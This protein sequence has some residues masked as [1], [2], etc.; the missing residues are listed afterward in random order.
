MLGYGSHNRNAAEQAYGLIEKGNLDLAPLI[1]RRLPLSQ[2]TEGVS[3]LR[4][5]EAIKILFVPWD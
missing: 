4:N 5:R 3:L 2:Y 1:T